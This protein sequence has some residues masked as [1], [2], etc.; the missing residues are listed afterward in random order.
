MYTFDFETHSIEPRPDYPPEPVGMAHADDHDRPVYLAWGHPSGNNAGTFIV[1]TNA[2]QDRWRGALLCHNAAFDLAVAT[3][4]LG[5]PLPAGTQVND[6]MF[7][8]F[9]LDPH[10]ELSLKPLA[11]RYLH[12]PP[13]ERDAVR[14]WLYAHKVVRKN[15]KSW[16]AHISRAPGELVGPYACGDVTRTREL[17]D[18]LM[19]LV[20]QAGMSDAYRRECDLVP[21]L[22]ENSARGIPLD[23]ERIGRDLV[24]YE[25]QMATVEAQLRREWRRQ[26]PSVPP[27]A[28]WGSTE[29]LAEQLVAARVNNLPRTPKGRVSTARDGLL[30]ALPDTPL[31]ALLA[32]HSAVSYTLSNYLRPWHEQ[33][34]ALHC[35][36]NQIRD[37]NDRGAR[38]G[39]LSSS[40]NL[41]NMT[42][43]EKYDRVHEVIAR[44]R[45]KLLPLPNL[46]SYIV[47]PK[48]HVLFSRDYSQQELRLLA[49]FEDGPLHAAYCA[50]PSLDV[51]VHLGRLIQQRFGLAL[52]RKITKALNFSKIYGAGAPHLSATLAKPIEEV[53]QLV[54]AYEAA[55]PGVVAL[56]AEIKG[57]GRRGEYVRTLGGRRYHTE[58]PKVIDGR[59]RSFEYKLLNHLIQGSGA[60]Q[61]KEAMR[62]WYSAIR[63]TPTRFLLT[64]HDQL[65]GCC[66][67]RDVRRESAKLDEAMLEAFEL[68][69]PVKTDPTYGYNFGAMTPEV[70]R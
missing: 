9:L 23:H 56:S 67:K 45:L 3:E 64:I 68:D 53:Y 55:M 10:G 37:Y 18:H 41:Q 29:Q 38:T 61:T 28:N 62:G 16:G 70:P 6:T 40:P 58:P 14:D 69:V 49:Y 26:F 4:V 12:I 52:P 66:P 63:G 65:V 46:R 7:L 51:H 42:N 32:Y 17:F 22:L 21:M 31:S 50:E 34:K 2:L 54:A 20:E 39:R 35:N 59:L 47:A 43:V 36:W 24:A 1:G 44:H 57:I 19:P 13:T 60:D 33:G 15:L 48:G 8:A 5:L 25:D 30:D 11:E 27:P